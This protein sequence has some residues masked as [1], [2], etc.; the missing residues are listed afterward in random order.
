MNHFPPP[1]AQQLRQARIASMGEMVASI[2]HEVHQ[3]IAAMTLNAQA[4]LLCLE[5]AEPAT[6]QARAALLAL[7]EA[8]N[9]AN[10]LLR[11]IRNLSQNTSVAPRL[12]RL[13]DAVSAVT[14]LLRGELDRHRIVLRLRL[15]AAPHS[16][17]ADPV[18][19]QQVLLNLCCNAIDAMRGSDACPREL[20]ITSRAGD[21]NMLVVSVADNGA[22]LPPGA[23]S[24][25]F[26]P[27]YTTKENGMGMGLAICRSIVQA[28]GGSIE[29]AARPGQGSVFHFTLPHE[30]LAARPATP[31]HQEFHV[32]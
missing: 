20:I 10:A 2:S 26:E 24:R 13:A 18:Q 22:G 29:A 25:L 21:N 12:V 7:L 31:Q 8:A 27:L 1:T 16:V 14:G 17:M 3:P 11:S 30:A 15:A 5:R 4:A 9:H 19:L 23:A 6:E 28:H 32:D